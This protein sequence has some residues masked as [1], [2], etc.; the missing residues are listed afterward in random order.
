MEGTF[1]KPSWEHVLPNKRMWSSFT[2][3]QTQGGKTTGKSTMEGELKDNVALLQ[4]LDGS[5]E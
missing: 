4:V 1:S 5:D 2:T 3:G